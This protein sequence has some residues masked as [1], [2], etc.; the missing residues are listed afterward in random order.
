[1]Y[2]W[3]ITHT[4]KTE[5]LNKFYRVQTLKTEQKDW[6][7][8]IIKDKK[9]LNLKISDDEVKNMSKNKFKS[10]ISQKI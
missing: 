4:D 10:I 8:Q 2:W 6:I 9:D 1:M 3:H 5:I 7:K